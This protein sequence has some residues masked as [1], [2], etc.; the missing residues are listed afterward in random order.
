MVVGPIFAALIGAALGGFIRDWINE[1][2]FKPKL[3]I[4]DKSV[5]KG[6]HYRIIV[7]NEGK[8]AAENCIGMITLDAEAEDVYE[9]SDVYIISADEPQPILSSK[10]FTP[11]E[12][13]SLCWSR[14]GN[15]ETCTINRNTKAALEFC[16][17]Y[18]ESHLSI[19]SESGWLPVRVRLKIGEYHGKIEVTSANAEPACA[20]FNLVPQGDGMTL[21]IIRRVPDWDD[22]QRRLTRRV[23]LWCKQKIKVLGR[24]KKNARTT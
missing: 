14:M 8:R 20:S 13:M 19:P 3:Y 5:I 12:G 24:S 6:L 2:Y 7:K 9:P 16:M 4:L 11:M 10:Y 15:I 23:R 17:V 1:N 21:E 18:A 22:Y